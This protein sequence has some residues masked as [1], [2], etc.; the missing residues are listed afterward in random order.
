[1]PSPIKLESRF[2]VRF[3][4]FAL[5]VFSLCCSAG[6]SQAPPNAGAPAGSATTDDGP[7][8]QVVDAE[9]LLVKSDWKGAEAKL[10]PWLA[11]H[12]KDAR[13]L[14]DAGYAAD[15]QNKLDDAAEF[16][17]RA[18]EADPKRF[19]A[20]L[21][22]GL[23]LARQGKLAE[24]REELQTST[25]LDPGEAGQAAKAR[26]WRALAQVDRGDNPSQASEDLLQAL[27]LSPEKP[28][29]TLLAAELAEK[30]GQPDAAESAYLRL[31]TDDPASAPAD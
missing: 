9:S 28:E 5:A 24:A 18:V 19:E 22:L 13:G 25:Q 20:H 11:E 29:D 7:S 14:F 17:H 27:K 2:C 16:Y 10:T 31:L 3:I 12:P 26:A 8:Q 23:L 21:S 6:L 1:M 15:A 4:G 30:S